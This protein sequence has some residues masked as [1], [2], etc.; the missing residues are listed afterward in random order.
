MFD[1]SV[2]VDKGEKEKKQEVPQNRFMKNPMELTWGHTMD[3][4]GKTGYLSCASP[5]CTKE[6]F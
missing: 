2:T 4:L 3:L 6:S 5:E 1:L